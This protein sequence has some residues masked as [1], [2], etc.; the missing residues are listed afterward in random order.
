MPRCQIQSSASI[1]VHLFPLK[2]STSED[3]SSPNLG[4]FRLNYHYHRIQKKVLSTSLILSNF[5]NN[6]ALRK[7]KSNIYEPLGLNMCRMVGFYQLL[8]ELRFHNNNY[9]YQVFHFCL[10]IDLDRICQLCLLVQFYVKKSRIICPTLTN[11]N[12]DRLQL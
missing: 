8:L 11:Y 1:S 2:P 10:Q 3:S 12:S 4:H 9:I 7:E 5:H 6:V